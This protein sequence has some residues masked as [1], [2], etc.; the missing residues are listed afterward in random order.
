[1]TRRDAEWRADALRECFEQRM[2]PLECAEHIGVTRA[3]IY[4]IFAGREWKNIPR[5]EGFVYPFPGVKPF[6]RRNKRSKC[7]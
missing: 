2:T 7:K 3:Q 1:M 5:P 4:A 6:T